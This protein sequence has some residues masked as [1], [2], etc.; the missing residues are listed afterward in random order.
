MK[1]L[2][3]YL[4]NF[5][6]TI[7]RDH[8]MSKKQILIGHI[9]LF[10]LIISATAQQQRSD[11]RIRGT[12]TKYEPGD[13][14]S[15]SW[16][17]YVS[18]LAEGREYVYFG[19]TGGVLRYDFYAN[20]WE[21]PWTTS[22]G[23]ADNF[24]RVVAYDFNTDYLWCATP[25]GVSVYRSNFRRWEN[26][27]ND[28]LGLSADDEII[29]IG[30]DDRF[31][32]LESKR[33]Q[34]LESQNQQG[35]FIRVTP[36]DVPMQQIEWYGVR[37]NNL[38]NLPNFMMHDGYFFDPS[39]YIRDYRLN[40]YPVTS[41]LNGRWGVMWV[42]SW[43]AGA[44]KAD[45]RIQILELLPYG[46]FIKNVN[47]LKMDS[48]GNIW[49]GGI[50]I[51]NEE[52]GITFWNRRSNRWSNFQARY[53]N[54]LYSDQVTSI[55]I[56]DSCIWFGTQHGVACFTPKSNDW[57]SFDVSAGLGDNYVFDVEVDE[58]NVWIGT[59][60]GLSR[61]I[62]D[63]LNTKKFRIQQLARQDLLWKKVYAIELMQNLVWLGTEYGVYIYDA[64]SDSGGFENDP[65]GPMNDPVLAI[66]CFEDKEVWFGLADGIEMFDMKSKT[67]GGAPQRRFLDAT[68]VNY[69]AVDSASA[70][71]ATNNGALKFDKANKRWVRF[72]TADGL[73]SNQ[74]NCVLLEGDYVWFGT[75]EGMTRFYWNAPYRID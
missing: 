70:W 74:V 8:S 37:G 60:N 58:E 43:G 38:K 9:M 30:F 34:F 63:S 49:A 7:I 29:S 66:G 10:V 64:A 35:Y 65:N 67:W 13:W 55:A 12:N 68:L 1:H 73:L 3:A 16:N 62:K 14:T 61:I 20:R 25:Q 33:G 42:G 72:T 40:N 4:L 24:V 31:I 59:A 53:N 54:R 75:P 27:F 6:Q 69:I 56:D 71:F 18:S 28:E 22:D 15:Y 51:Y 23:L 48:E 52:S 57:R 46:L 50:G 21:S 44:G 17:R 26:F 47:A 41:F 39:G 5:F 19:T 11:G 36:F 45:Y 32:W 2:G